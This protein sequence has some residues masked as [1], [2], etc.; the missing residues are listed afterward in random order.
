[1]L[2]WDKLAPALIL[3]LIGY[4]I[5]DVSTIKTD[6]AVSKIKLEHVEEKVADNHQMITPM[7]RQF[8]MEKADDVAV[9]NASAD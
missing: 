4:L 5:S 2:T 3:A 6:V 1:M 8:L 9:L 7:W